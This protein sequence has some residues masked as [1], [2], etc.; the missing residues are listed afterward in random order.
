MSPIL[1]VMAIALLPVAGNL[2]GIVLAETV[3]TP[4]WLVGASLHA[5]A[6]IAIA[7]VSI[8][9]MPRVLET[10]PVWLIIVA[11]LAGA[12]LSLL[13]ALLVHA[14]AG[15][16]RGRGRAWM[17]WVAV[18]ADL[19]GDGVMTGVG[20]A[21]TSGLGLLIAISQSV[22]NIPGGFAASANLQSDGVTRRRRWAI[23]LLLAIPVLVS[24]GLGFWLL[25]GAEPFVQNAALA[26]IVGVLLVTTVED[27]VPEADAPQ[28]KRW[29]S[30]TAFA[31]GFALLA[32]LS[33]L[34]R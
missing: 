21:V 2:I 25:R 18:A 32:T 28:P 27:V 8:E 31:A 20:S 14:G 11:F 5:A 6:G 17:V 23:S 10:T 1:I 26:A 16:T 4:R 24:A 9:L 7:V 12:F 22:A 30:T 15:R 34:V 29:I 33:A 3:R 19:F 13:L